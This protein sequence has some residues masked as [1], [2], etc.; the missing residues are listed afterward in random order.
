LH[1]QAADLGCCC[2]GVPFARLLVD[3]GFVVTGVDVSEVQIDRA[4]RLDSGATFLCADLATWDVL[5]NTFEV[6]VSRYASIEVP[7]E[8][9]RRLIP[10]LAWWLV[11]DGYLLAILGHQKWKGVEDYMGAPIWTT[12]VTAAV[13]PAAAVRSPGWERMADALAPSSRT[14]GSWLDER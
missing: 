11:P 12:P 14:S 13:R 9:Q 4:R 6:I 7:V 5:L 10:R 1:T 8:D 2:A 3:A